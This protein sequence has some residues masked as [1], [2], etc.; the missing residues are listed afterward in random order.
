MTERADH[1]HHDNAPAHSTA[2]VQAFLAKNHIIQVCQPLYSPDLLPTTSGFS[3]I[4]VPAILI[5]IS[6]FYCSL[7]H[8]IAITSPELPPTHISARIF[9][10]PA[11]VNGTC[12]VSQALHRVPELPATGT[13]INTLRTG[14]LNCLNARSRGLTF[15]HPASYIAGQA[16][17]YSPEDA[18]Y[19][20][21]QQIYFII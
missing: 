19:I 12:S 20:F 5:C 16:F 4:A 15:R 1:L 17:R 18:I 2:L 8:I 14:L 9:I 6:L 3:Q 10:M 13:A 11:C 21:N 7:F